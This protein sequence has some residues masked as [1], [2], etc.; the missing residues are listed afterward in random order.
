MGSDRWWGGGF[1][2]VLDS[3]EIRVPVHMTRGR[4]ARVRIS[5]RAE[6]KIWVQLSVWG[7]VSVTVPVAAGNLHLIN[8]SRLGSELGSGLNC[9]N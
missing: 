3:V 2:K 1:W 7:P 8:W 9:S 6:F 5:H 4:E